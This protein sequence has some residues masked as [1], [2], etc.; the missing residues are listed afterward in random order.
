M[1][2]SGNFQENK[3]IKFQ[4]KFMYVLSSIVLPSLKQRLLVL[5]DYNTIEP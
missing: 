3:F 4:I 1:K 2:E 5:I